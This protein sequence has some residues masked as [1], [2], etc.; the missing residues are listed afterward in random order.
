[1]FGKAFTF[2][3]LPVLIAATGAAIAFGSNQESG[4]VIDYSFEV[5]YIVDYVE[6]I[7]LNRSNDFVNNIEKVPEFMDPDP[8]I[9]EDLLCPNYYLLAK[10]VGWDESE[11]R[12][13]DYVIWRE[14]RCDSSAHNKFDPSSGS[15]GIIQ[16]NGFWCLPNQYTENGFLQDHGVLDICEE[17]FDPETNLKAGLVIYNYGIDKHGCGWG[18]WST[19][20]SAW[21]KS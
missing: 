3:I 8:V 10:D 20:R 4:I 5:V 17:L 18:P 13:L 21:C 19:K 15:R 6:D 16:I 7:S 2:V 1:M 9:P 12:K 11:S 14:S